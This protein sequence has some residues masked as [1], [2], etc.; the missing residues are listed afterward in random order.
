MKATSREKNSVNYMKRWSGYQGLETARPGLARPHTAARTGRVTTQ[1]ARHAQRTHGT[2]TR[3]RTSTAHQ[4]T[5]ERTG[6]T[7]RT[8]RRQ[9]AKRTKHARTRARACASFCVFPRSFSRTPSRDA[10]CSNKPALFHI[11]RNRIPS[12]ALVLG[13]V[14]IFHAFSVPATGL[15][16]VNLNFL[17]YASARYCAW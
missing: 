7:S 16:L 9:H 3:G 17:T 4:H 6:R 12:Y 10:C 14:D 11:G 1:H 8:H 5:T 13:R 15:K 2:H